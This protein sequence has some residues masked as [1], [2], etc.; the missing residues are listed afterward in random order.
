M[1]W[2]D[3]IYYR[4]YKWYEKKDAHPWIYARGLISVLQTFLVFDIFIIF[5]E[6]TPERLYSEVGE[7]ILILIIFILLLAFNIYRYKILISIEKL[8]NLYTSDP[9]KG[10]LIVLIIVLVISP[11]FILGV[12]RH[13]LGLID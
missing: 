11:P 13:N 9:K 5:Q 7:K 3:Y 1:K 2:F 6:F 8:D 10:I 12:L 4:I